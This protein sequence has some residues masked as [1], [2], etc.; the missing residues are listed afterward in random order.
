MKM[1]QALAIFIGLFL[2]WILIIAGVTAEIYNAWLY[3][4]SITW[5]LMSVVFLLSFYK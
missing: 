5:F 3:V 1:K 2:P 4:G